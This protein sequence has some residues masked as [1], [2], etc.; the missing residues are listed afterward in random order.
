MV[1]HLRA[2]QGL[3]FVQRDQ[4]GLGPGLRDIKGLLRSKTNHHFHHFDGDAEVDVEGVLVCATF[5][6]WRNRGPEGPDIKAAER[7]NHLQH[8]CVKF[9]YCSHHIREDCR[10]ERGRVGVGAPKQEDGRF[11]DLVPI[12]YISP[13]VVLHDHILS[14]GGEIL[15]GR[16]DYIGEP[17]SPGRY[18]RPWWGRHHLL[19]LELR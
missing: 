7:E 1:G 15:T 12:P 10:L 9:G 18:I 16:R 11:S 5:E 2:H 19:L 8:A 14:H 17:G 4:Q 6:L 13:C 3:F